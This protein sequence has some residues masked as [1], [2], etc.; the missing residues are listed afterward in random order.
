[1]EDFET[2]QECRDRIKTRSDR[3]LCGIREGLGSCSNPNLC[4]TAFDV[5][6]GD[7]PH[8]REKECGD[9]PHFHKY[10]SDTR[11]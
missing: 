7:I 10:P 3:V 11:R 6:Y 4:A 9:C 5:R 2:A 8:I 1:M